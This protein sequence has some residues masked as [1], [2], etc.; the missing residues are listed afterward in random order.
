MVMQISRSDEKATGKQTTE[1]IEKPNTTNH[2]SN[3][4]FGTVVFWMLLIVRVRNT[5]KTAT[6]PT[7]SDMIAA[8]APTQQRPTE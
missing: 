5:R 8:T 2:S 7:R 3:G 6:I 1:R 4:L